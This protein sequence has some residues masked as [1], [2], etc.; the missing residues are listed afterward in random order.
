MQ[1]LPNPLGNVPRI[2]RVPFEACHGVQR[3]CDDLATPQVLL[4]ATRLDTSR[5][6]VR[7]PGDVASD[8]DVCFVVSD[9]PLDPSELGAI[10]GAQ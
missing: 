5:P 7:T 9:D 4:P 8:R 3:R 6:D 1:K 2:E 10:P